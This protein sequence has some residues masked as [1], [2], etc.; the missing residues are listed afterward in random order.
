M[1]RSCRSRPSTPAPGA[2]VRQRRLAGAQPA[3]RGGRV[4]G[5]ANATVPANT[6]SAVSL[7]AGADDQLLHRREEPRSPEAR[8][9]DQQRGSDEFDNTLGTTVA[10]DI[11]NLQISYDLADGNANPANVRFVAADFTAGGACAPAACSVNQIRKVNITL[12]GRSQR[13]ATVSREYFRNS[14]T[15]Q[16]SLRGMAFV[17]EYFQ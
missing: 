12:T 13:P 3:D 11:E 17:D 7:T 14:V 1:R 6:P 15:T 16:V 4:A 5:R 8:P 10:F 2:R 9:A